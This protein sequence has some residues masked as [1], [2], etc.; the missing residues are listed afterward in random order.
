MASK[1][2]NKVIHGNWWKKLLIAIAMLVLFL[3]FVNWLLKYMTNHGETLPVPKVTGLT[4]EEA[5]QLLEGKDLRCIAYDSVYV[6]KAKPNEVIDQN[7]SDSSLVKRNRMIYLTINALAVPIVEVP[8][9]RE[10][11][12][13]EATS[14]LQRAGLRV[15]KIT[16][17]PDI[18]TNFVLDQRY[19]GRY[20]KPGTKLDK[21][22][23]IDLVI[24]KGEEPEDA[25]IT[26][27]DLSGL[28]AEDATTELN[29]LGLNIG[30]ITYD[31]D[32]EDKAFAVIY[33]Q[34][35]RAGSKTYIGKEIDIY[36]KEVE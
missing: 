21:G 18:T 4:Y 13:R 9:V 24:S 26:V 23:A 35:V 28:T 29:L 25:E 12:L 1:F 3:L 30:V 27:P 19:E 16:T 11:S 5:K 36:L 33:K 20:I 7:P 31:K 10:M 32:V 22:T 34:S 15:G 6:P 8:D 2:V 17:R 14:S